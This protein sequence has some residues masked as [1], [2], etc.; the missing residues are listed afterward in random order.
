[1]SCGGHF[2]GGTTIEEAKEALAA[3]EDLT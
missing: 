1:M 3:G 2:S